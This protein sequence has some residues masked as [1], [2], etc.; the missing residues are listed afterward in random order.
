MI[1]RFFLLFTIPILVYA[2][3]D[4][5]LILAEQNKLYEKNEWKALL[6]YDNDFKV[7]D[8]KFLLSKN[9]SLKNELISTIKAFYDLPSHY[10]NINE[11]PQCRFPARLLFITHE[12][13]ISK[14]EFPK[15]N[16]R[17]LGIYK[18]K[19]PAD[20]ISLVMLLKM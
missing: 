17:N 5:T 18:E 7:T 12:L 15:V 11:H 4:N 13:N 8:K 20:E 3:Q 14:D 16:C 1:R 10:L 19:A 9:L 2:S 6:H